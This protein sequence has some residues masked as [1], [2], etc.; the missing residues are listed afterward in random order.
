VAE[1]GWVAVLVWGLFPLLGAGALA[2][3]NA[4]TGWMVKLPWA[5]LKIPAK[6]VDDLPEPAATIGALAIGA[7]AGLIVAGMAVSEQLTVT[8]AADRVSLARGGGA[9]GSMDRAAVDL[10]FMD[11]KRLVLLDAAGAELARESSDLPAERLRDAFQEH[12]YRWAAEDPHRDEYRLWVAPVTELPD[13][14]NVLLTA[15]RKALKDG[16]TND[17]ARLRTELARLGFVVREEQ[18]H[19]Y[20]RRVDQQPKHTDSAPAGKKADPAGG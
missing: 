2:A 5:P 1:P 15:R 4:L 8:V 14:V 12:G 6:L 13:S 10:V 18:K 3:L 7:I 20:W 16:R 17:V 9:V 19:Q 11:G